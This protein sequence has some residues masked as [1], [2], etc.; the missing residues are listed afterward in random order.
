MGS[1]TGD[2]HWRWDGDGGGD[3]DGDGGGDGDGDGGGDGDGDRDGLVLDDGS[4][5][6]LS[7]AGKVRKRTLIDHS[8]LGSQV[9]DTQHQ[10]H[11][12]HQI[13]GLEVGTSNEFNGTRTHTHTHRRHVFNM[14]HFIDHRQS[15]KPPSRP[16]R[17]HNIVSRMGTR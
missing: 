13:T 2:G 3:G 17:K 7:P 6:L 16:K 15:T 8:I 14:S 11:L 5:C 10:R 4:C 12:F 1:G 9:P